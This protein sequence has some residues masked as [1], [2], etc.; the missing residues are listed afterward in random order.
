MDVCDERDVTLADRRAR[1]SVVA[2]ISFSD[3]FP[4]VNIMSY[5]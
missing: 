5:S 1:L 4:P 2:R 3:S